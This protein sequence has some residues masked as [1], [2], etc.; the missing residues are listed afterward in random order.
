MVVTD[1]SF[2]DMGTMAVGVLTERSDK[3]IGVD[4]ES[5]SS[6]LAMAARAGVL[7]VLRATFLGRRMMVI[8]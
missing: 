2:V 4:L 7:R 1:G 3:L 6:A 8:R 5:V